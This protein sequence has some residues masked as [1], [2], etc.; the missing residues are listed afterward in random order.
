[1]LLNHYGVK[2]HMTYDKHP[3]EVGLPKLDE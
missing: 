1:V 2:S 3:K